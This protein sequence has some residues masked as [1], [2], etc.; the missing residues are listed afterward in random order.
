MN[1]QSSIRSLLIV[2]FL[3]IAMSS[4]YSQSNIHKKAFYAEAFGPGLIYSMNYDWRFKNDYKGHGARIGISALN[5]SEGFWAAIP[6]SYNFI[7]SKDFKTSIELGAGMTFALGEAD[8][9]NFNDKLVFGH[10]IVGIRYRPFENSF[11]LK[12]GWTPIFTDDKTSYIFGNIGLGFS[13]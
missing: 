1:F 3:A 12:A 13:I 5:F 9:A 11:F 6:I 4:G 8:F 2:S 10:L 7:F